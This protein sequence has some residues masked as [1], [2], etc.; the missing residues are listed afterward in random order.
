MLD[1]PVRYTRTAVALHWLLA[2]LIL[3]QIAF[4]WYLDEVPRGTPER[5]IFVNL[6]K[7]IGMVLGLI[8]LLRLYW[9]ITHAAPAL[10]G[11]M[12]R[13]EQSTA[14]VTHAAL[15]VCMLLMP[16]SG[17]TASNFSKWGVNF[18]NAV[19]LPP[20]GVNSP[21][22][23][24]ALNTTHIVT[25]W[26]FVALIAGHVLAAVRHLILRDRIFQRMWPVGR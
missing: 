17:Y 20:W 13:W 3:G 2:L 11:T 16:L 24:D 10:P 21:A 1:A 9:R 5:T 15:Y 19:K 22:V 18:F 25:S 14:R 12:A 4:G 7:S 8:I 6:H 23:Y 26:I